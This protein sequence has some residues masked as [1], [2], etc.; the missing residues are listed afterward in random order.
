MRGK[1]CG[2]FILSEH[3]CSSVVLMVKTV[4]SSYECVKY[5]SLLN[6]LRGNCFDDE[7]YVY[8]TNSRGTKARSWSW[9]CHSGL[10]LGLGLVSFGLGLGLVVLVLVLVLR[11]WSC[12]HH[13]SFL[14]C[15][16]H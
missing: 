15:W 10:D 5:S 6:T 9:S 14:D 16:H 4:M 7:Q 2:V 1:M 13:W 8:C 3:T 11:I 12:S